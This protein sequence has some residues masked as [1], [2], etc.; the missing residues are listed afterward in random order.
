MGKK[1]KLTLVDQTAATSLAPPT[2]LG[3]AGR[4]LWQSIMSEYAIDDSAGL[5]MLEQITAAADRL[6]EYA[7]AIER[8]GPMI[9]TRHGAREHPLLKHELATRSF[10]VRTLERL[11]IGIESLKAIGRPT[12]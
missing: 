10:I 11:G 7:E 6:T 1:P 5:Q 9:N 12:Q 4:T 3:K 2:T 8:D